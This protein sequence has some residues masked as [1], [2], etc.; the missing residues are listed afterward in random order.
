M[1]AARKLPNVTDEPEE[2]RRVWAAVHEES[3]VRLLYVDR[4]FIWNAIAHELAEKIRRHY[5]GNSDPLGRHATL[6]VTNAWSAANLIDPGP[7]V[8]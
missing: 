2:R 5:F 8:E 1:G 7:G 3:G 4:Q 6:P